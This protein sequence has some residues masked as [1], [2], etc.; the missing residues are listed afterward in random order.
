MSS[1][2]PGRRWEGEERRGE[3]EGRRGEG[4]GSGR[5]RADKDIFLFHIEQ[6]QRR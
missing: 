2:V 4:E 5:Q 3:D 1:S 6:S